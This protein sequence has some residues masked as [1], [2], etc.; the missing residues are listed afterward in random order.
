MS[1]Y[2]IKSI[3]SL[4]GHFFHNE[5]GWKRVDDLVQKQ[6]ISRCKVANNWL[7]HYGARSPPCLSSY[8][9]SFLCPRTGIGPQLPHLLLVTIKTIKQAGNGRVTSSKPDQRFNHC[10]I[11]LGPT[12]PL[13][14]G[15]P[16]KYHPTQKRKF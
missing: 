15:G 6:T 13:A 11:Y 10:L 14:V 9:L 1:S 12:T 16:Y 7:T 5:T 3:S 8:P 2:F 4:S